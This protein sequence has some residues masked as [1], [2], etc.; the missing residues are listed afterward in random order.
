[1]VEVDNVAKIVR[2]SNKDAN[3]STLSFERVNEHWEA[4]L[5]PNLVK[6]SDR[7]ME[8]LIDGL[9]ELRKG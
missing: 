5:G 9:Q 6:L 7:E 4:W 2:V 1:M 3:Q 8:Q